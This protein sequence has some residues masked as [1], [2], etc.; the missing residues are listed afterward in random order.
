MG[1]MKSQALVKSPGK[2]ASKGQLFLDFLFLWQL[3][4]LPLRTPRED[5][6][7]HPAILKLRVGQPYCQTF[8]A[9]EAYSAE[10]D[11]S[12]RSTMQEENV[13]KSANEQAI[14]TLMI[15]QGTAN[16]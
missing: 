15:G 7:A 2:L 11:T 14:L 13:L 5:L 3:L 9:L 8:K 12:R 10:G 1:G 6:A 4:K 16:I